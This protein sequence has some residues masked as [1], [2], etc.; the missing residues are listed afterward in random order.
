M[1]KSSLI[2]LNFL[3]CALFVRAQINSGKKILIV[4]TSANNTI[5]RP[6]DHT[7]GCYGP[8]VSD[9]Y[10]K[11][12]QAGFRIKDVDIVSPKGGSVPLA[13]NLHYSKKL[14]IPENE[15]K[16]L[17]DKLKNSLTPMQVKPDD[18][19]VIY[20]AGGFSCLVDYPDSNGIE[21]I[22]ASIYEKGG[23]VSAV[24]DGI[25]GLIPIKL[26]NNTHLIE[27]KN[28]TTNGY[29]SQNDRIRERLAENGAIIGSPK[30]IVDRHIITARGVRPVAV[31]TEVLKLL[32]YPY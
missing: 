2:L 27:N 21:A 14:P 23:I 24:C 3:L 1:N 18:Y 7:W 5:S 8:E 25:C 10:S 6:N 19:N 29:K 12:Y 28:I 32:G 20:Y 13:F 15:K 31:A 17:E 30:V 16:A 4:A 11:I 22:A 9:F 26:H